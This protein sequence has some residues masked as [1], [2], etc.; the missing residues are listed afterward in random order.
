MDASQLVGQSDGQ[1]SRANLKRRF[2]RPEKVVLVRL[3]RR[4][5]QTLPL[6]LPLNRSQSEI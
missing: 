5:P 4:A 6:F 1:A 3:C 2:V